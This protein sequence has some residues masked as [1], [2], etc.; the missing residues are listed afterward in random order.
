MK[1]RPW[2][3]PG[4]AAAHGAASRW[5]RRWPALARSS[6]EVGTRRHRHRRPDGGTA[7]KPVGTVVFA[8]VTLTPASCGR[9]RIQLR[10]GCA[11]RR[12]SRRSTWRG[13]S[14]PAFACRED[15]A[16]HHRAASHWRLAGR[17]TL[18]ETHCVMPDSPSPSIGY[19][20]GSIPSRFWSRG[21]GHRRRRAGSGNVGA[22]NVLRTSGVVTAVCVMPLIWRKALALCSA[23]R[24]GSRRYRGP[25]LLVWRPSSSIYPV[26]L[27]FRGGRASRPP[28][29]CSVL[30]PVALA[31]ARPVRAD[32]GSRVCLLGSL[33]ATVA[34][35]RSR[36]ASGAGAS[37]LRRARVG[38]LIV[39]RAPTNI[40][41]L[42][43]GTGRRV[44]ERVRRGR[45]QSLGGALRHGARRP[46]CS[47]GTWSGCGRDPALAAEM[48]RRRSNPAYLRI[49]HFRSRSRDERAER[50]LEDC[51]LVV[52]V[53]PPHG[54][55]T[56]LRA[57]PLVRLHAVIVS[58]SRA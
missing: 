45:S 52:S 14:S 1:T 33:V 4:V 40:M 11:R 34:S 44:G 26:W 51:D 55:E 3:F 39:F 37:R 49:W 5:P 56:S 32:G 16:R 53:V 2:A 47:R 27:K 9:G 36:R 57:R 24:G 22:T 21:P 25:P 30:T 41:Q 54:T 38:A 50:A 13:G 8:V 42:I 19:P 6:A 17:V 18:Y 10:R 48:A 12:Q 35:G 23:S 31:P 28:P 46:S 29:A 15:R 20:A 7:D 58:A 43:S